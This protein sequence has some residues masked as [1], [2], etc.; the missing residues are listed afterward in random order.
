[1]TDGNETQAKGAGQTPPQ[2]P[3]P[4]GSIDVPQPTR[5]QVEYLSKVEAS[6]RRGYDESVVVGGPRRQKA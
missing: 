6:S 2:L 3:T 4:R 1:M 5:D